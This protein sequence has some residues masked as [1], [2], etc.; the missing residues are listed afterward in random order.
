[1]V[2]NGT[3]DG[4]AWKFWWVYPIATAMGGVVAGSFLHLNKQSQLAIKK[5]S[6]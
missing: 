6:D 4:L 5:T 1:M 3:L 2:H